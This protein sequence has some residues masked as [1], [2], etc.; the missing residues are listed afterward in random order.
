MLGIVR[1]KPHSL[2]GFIPLESQ[3][4]LRRSRIDTGHWLTATAEPLP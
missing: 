2:G 4:S 3:R 1:E